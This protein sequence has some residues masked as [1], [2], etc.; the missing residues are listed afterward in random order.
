[1][2]PYSPDLNPGCE[3]QFWLKVVEE[4]KRGIAKNNFLLYC[5]GSTSRI[6]VKQ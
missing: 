2:P 1:M 5:P 4:D 3:I 6:A